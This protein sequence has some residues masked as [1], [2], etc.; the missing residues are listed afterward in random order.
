[1]PWGKVSQPRTLCLCGTP[2]EMGAEHG[3]LLRDEIHENMC[4]YVRRS[5]E[6]FEVPYEY[7]IRKVDEILPFIPD[8]FSREIR[9]LAESARV[10][11]RELLAFNCLVD[12]DATYMQ[13]LS[14]CCNF[15]LVPPAISDSTIHGRNLDFPHAGVLPRTAVALVRCPEDTSRCETISVAWAGYVGILTG[16]NSMGISVGEVGVPAR[17]CTAQGVPISIL[18]RDALE[19][20]TTMDVFHDKVG[21]TPRTGGY[22]IAV[23]DAVNMSSLAIECTRVQCEFRKA[24]KGVLV[25]DDVCL[26][27]KTGLHRLVHASGAFRHAR[28]VQLILRASDSFSLDTAIQCLGD[29]YDMATGRAHGRGYN[30]ICNS[31]TIHSVVFTGDSVWI[32]QGVTP[33]PTGGYHRLELS[34]FWSRR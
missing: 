19:S 10:D 28:M 21:R 31:H 8:R 30:C 5:R 3:E 13:N 27:K 29:R 20:S 17:D 33:A 6:I 34:E 11:F 15:V 1:M 25:V 23:C 32:A 4:E 9:A 24:K 12:I 14:H 18:I 2:E 7:L 16:C 22:N 26:C